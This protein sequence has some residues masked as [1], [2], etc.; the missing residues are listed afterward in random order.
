MNWEFDYALLYSKFCIEKGNY[1]KLKN[2]WWN[3]YICSSSQYVSSSAKNCE[4]FYIVLISL[5]KAAGGY[6]FTSYF[7]LTSLLKVLWLFVCGK[8]L[9]LL[10]SLSLQILEESQAFLLRSTDSWEWSNFCSFKCGLLKHCPWFRYFCFIC[11]MS[12]LKEILLLC[13]TSK[14]GMQI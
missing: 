13:F 11:L 14:T 3:P 7:L 1:L 10:V 9:N 4:S 2:L 8:N 5:S 6:F 12:E